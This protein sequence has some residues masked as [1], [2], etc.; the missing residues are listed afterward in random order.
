MADDLFRDSTMTFG[1]H[2]EELRSC[3]WKAIKGVGIALLLTTFV[4][5]EVVRILA[6]PLNS[7]LKHWHVTKRQE[8]F[9]TLKREFAEMSVESRSVDFEVTL[10]PASI[11]KLADKLGIALPQTPSEPIGVAVQAPLEPLLEKLLV[12]LV[13]LSGVFL[14]KTFAVQE[15]FMI[16]FKASL[17][18]ALILASPWVFWQLYGFIKVGLYAH[19]RR[20]VNLTLPF[21]VGLFLAGVAVCYWL[22]FPFMLRFFLGANDWMDLQPEIRLSEWV[23]FAVLLMLLNGVMF[24]LPVVMLVLERVGILTYEQ[25]AGKRRIAIMVNAFLAAVVTPADPVSMIMLAV[26]MCLLYEVGLLLMKYFQRHNPFAVA[27]PEMAEAEA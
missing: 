10:T 12:P 22:M 7:E 20:F 27:E 23:G 3:L 5:Q 18:A 8:R 19:E 1:E 9:E 25:L 21:T 2:I 15:G 4:G 14:P 13:E 16:Y 11:A 6:W 26:P 24:Q 17:G